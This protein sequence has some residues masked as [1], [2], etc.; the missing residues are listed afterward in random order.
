MESCYSGPFIVLRNVSIQNLYGDKLAPF[1]CLIS[2]VAFQVRQSLAS[3]TS[4]PIFDVRLIKDKLT[5]TSR[6]FCFVEF[7]SIEVSRKEDEFVLYNNSI[8]SKLFCLEPCS[9]SHL[10]SIYFKMSQQEEAY[11]QQTM[12]L[13]VL[14]CLLG[15]SV[16][17]PKEA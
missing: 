2:G 3:F 17:V 12:A 14:N 8:T 7:G 13:L 6:G 9:K 16:L 5:G 1:R 10:L 4:T 11:T 15:D